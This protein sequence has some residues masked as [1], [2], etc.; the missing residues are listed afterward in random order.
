MLQ[1]VQGGKGFFK[2]KRDITESARGK[3]FVRERRDFVDSAMGKG[4]V[5]ERSY[6]TM[7]GR[8]VSY[9]RDVILQS[10]GSKGFV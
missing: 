1:T 8:N 5:R 6:F 10:A 3:G 2:E 7:K 4:V 9:G